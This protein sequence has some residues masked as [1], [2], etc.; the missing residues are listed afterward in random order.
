MRDACEPWNDPAVRGAVLLT[1]LLVACAQSR[2]PHEADRAA[3]ADQASGGAGRPAAAGSG[4]GTAPVVAIRDAGESVPCTPDTRPGQACDEPYCQPVQ[5]GV[6]GQLECID[7]TWAPLG[8]PN[9]SAA[10]ISPWSFQ[11]EGDAGSGFCSLVGQCCGDPSASSGCPTENGCRFCP[12]TQPI[13]GEPCT[14]PAACDGHSGL[15]V[16]DCYY[17]CCCYG[18]PAWAQCDGERWRISSNCSS[19]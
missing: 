11:C 14:L 8:A 19:K 9:A 17:R 3:G 13:D 10:D 6:Q 4:A 15:K 1:W 18:G 5:C 16:I 2:A 12:A 7:G